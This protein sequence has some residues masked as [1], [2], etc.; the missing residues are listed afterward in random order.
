M[1]TIRYGKKT[2]VCRKEKNR[3]RLVCSPKKSG[4]HY[5]HKS[6]K[7]HGT[8]RGLAQD[9]KLK[10]KEPWEKAYRKK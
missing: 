7:G 6:H 8:R 3:N 5:V 2:Y 10:S 4:I 9:Q 1:K